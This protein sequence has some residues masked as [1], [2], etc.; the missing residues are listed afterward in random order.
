[1]LA[2]SGLRRLIVRAACSCCRPSTTSCNCAGVVAAT[3]FDRNGND[4]WNSNSTARIAKN[5]SL[6][7][8]SNCFL[9]SSTFS[10]TQNTWAKLDNGLAFSR[11]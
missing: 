3:I 7:D 10:S 5:K 4:C 1:M 9:N 8:H 6:R 11:L 2:S